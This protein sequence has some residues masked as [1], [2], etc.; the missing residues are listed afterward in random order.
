MNG[1]EVRVIL[2][3]ISRFHRDSVDVLHLW[4]ITLRHW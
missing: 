2:D 1:K 4:K 3:E